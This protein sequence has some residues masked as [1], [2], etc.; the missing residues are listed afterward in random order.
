M[1]VDLT[2]MAPLQIQAHASSR[3]GMFAAVD[4]C[5]PSVQVCF[6]ERRPLRFVVRSLKLCPTTRHTPSCGKQNNVGARQTIKRACQKAMQCSPMQRLKMRVC[7]V[8]YGQS[9]LPLKHPNGQRSA[10]PWTFFV[11]P[12]NRCFMTQGKWRPN[13]PWARQICSNSH[14]SVVDASKTCGFPQSKASIT[15]IVDPSKTLLTLVNMPS[16]RAP[17]K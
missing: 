3:L 14:E 4:A 11:C 7:I 16:N 13:V 1:G 5:D 12:G 8:L 15:A 17:S 10:M 2:L 9:I 6:P